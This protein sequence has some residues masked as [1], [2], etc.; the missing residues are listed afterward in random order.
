MRR[1]HRLNAKTV[2][3]AAHP[4]GKKSDHYLPDGAGLYLRVTASGAKSWAFVYMRNRRARE[5]GLGSILGVSLADARARAADARRLLANGADPIDAREAGRAEVARAAAHSITFAEAAK[6]Y[7]AANKAA[8]KNPKHIAQWEN[9]LTTYA[10]GVFGHVPVA[11]IDTALVLR[12][13]E[14]IWTEKHETATRLRQRIESVLAWATV[15]GYR[16]GENPA[17]W[18]GHLDQTLPKISKEERVEHFAALPYKDVSAFMPKLREQPGAAALA[19]ELT[20]L[21]AMRTEAVISAKPAEF[22]LADRI[23]TVPAERMKGKKRAAH[24][25]PLSAR[26]LAI[27]RER[28]SGGGEYLFPGLKEG[29]AMS[30]GAMLQLLDRMGRGDITVHGF[31]STFKDWASEQTAFPDIVSEMALGHTIPNKVEAAYRRGDL[32][33]KRRQLMDAWA[34]YCQ[35]KPRGEV[36]PIRPKR[37]KTAA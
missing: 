2:E 23:W 12:V 31:R 15:R 37:S 7:I 21:T 19:L 34:K 24:K 16:S 11:Q 29:K 14:P 17:R 4:G 26:A 20:I 22:D 28:I 32:L 13:L 33:E 25:V 3:H 36:V 9:T 10:G 27:V 8:W 1:L 18:K 5:M 35:T 30:N 6:R